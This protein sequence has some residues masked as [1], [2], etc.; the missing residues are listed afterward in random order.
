MAAVITSQARKTPGDRY[1]VYGT[2]TGDAAYPNGAGYPMTPAALG[3]SKIDFIF[4]QNSMSGFD[5]VADGNNNCR[6]FQGVN[7]APNAEV[8]NNTAGVNGA[9]FPFIAIGF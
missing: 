6:I 9:V 4:F 7:N 5:A 8:P 2:L 1:F 3:L